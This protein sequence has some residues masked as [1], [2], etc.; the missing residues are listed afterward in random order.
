MPAFKRFAKKEIEFS[1][2]FLAPFYHILVSFCV[3]FGPFIDVLGSYVSF[4]IRHYFGHIRVFSRSWANF[5]FFDM[6]QSPIFA[7]L[8]NLLR[9]QTKT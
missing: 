3:I 8:H 9:S 6:N 7:L 2:Y 5:Y 1:F 4:C